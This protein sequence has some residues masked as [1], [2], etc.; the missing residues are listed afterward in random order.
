M[1]SC[2][3]GVIDTQSSTCEVT[4]KIESSGVLMRGS[5]I[6]LCAAGNLAD[7]SEGRDACSP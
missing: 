1:R 6:V 3:V 4:D 2:K 7:K 5:L